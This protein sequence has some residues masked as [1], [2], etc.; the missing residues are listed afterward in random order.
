[1]LLNVTA[2][3]T[4]VTMSPASISVTDPLG[5][6]MAMTSKLCKQT[7]IWQINDTKKSE[8]L[9]LKVQNCTKIVTSLSGIKT[10]RVLY[11]HCRLGTCQCILTVSSVRGLFPLNFLCSC[12]LLMPI[13]GESGPELVPATNRCPLTPNI[14]SFLRSGEV[15]P[16]EGVRCR[17][18]LGLAGVSAGG[19]GWVL[20]DF[21]V[22]TERYQR[23]TLSLKSGKD[24][25]LCP[26][27][28]TIGLMP[29]SRRAQDVKSTE[30]QNVDRIL[31]QRDRLWLF[32]P[33]I[34]RILISSPVV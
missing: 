29:T 13:R 23:K 24:L 30:I 1:M 11:H 3:Q 9:S 25:H 2:D 17:A 28:H 21:P 10:I 33:K 18:S 8:F 5:G 20:F 6:R 12:A 19:T 32:T 15:S 14:S 22:P 34:N 7:D 4:V 31:S 27:S 26:I 16:L